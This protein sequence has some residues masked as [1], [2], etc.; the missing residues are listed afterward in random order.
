MPTHPFVSRFFVNTDE[1]RDE[2]IYKLPDTW[3]SRPFEYAWCTHFVSSHDVVLDAACGISH[4]LKFYLSEICEE[5]HACDLDA[6]IERM[7]DVLFEITADVGEEAAWEVQSTV[8]PRLHLSQANLTALPY[9]D[10]YFDTVFCISVLE[11][12]EP[13]DQFQALQEFNRILNDEGLLI[14]T[15]D[16][17]TVNLNMISA[18]LHYAGFQFWGETD[19]SLPPDAVR[20]EAWGGLNCF[21]AVLKKR[22]AT[23]RAV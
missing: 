21:R 4:P 19:F 23:E 8:T 10:E 20:T 11:H 18:L 13:Q 16:F 12:M 22:P 3:W 1:R 17:P 2:L 6:R 15:F 5:V 14:L 7:E 9:E